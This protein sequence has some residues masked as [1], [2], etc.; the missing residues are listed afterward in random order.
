MVTGSGIYA[1][2]WGMEVL[3]EHSE[4]WVIKK[5]GESAAACAQTQQK[6]H[7]REW[8]GDWVMPRSPCRSQGAVTQLHFWGDRKERWLQIRSSVSMSQTC[9]WGWSQNVFNTLLAR[10]W[11]DLSLLG[12]ANM[13]L[14]SCSALRMILSS[15][16]RDPPQVRALCHSVSISSPQSLLGTEWMGG[17]EEGRR[18]EKVCS[19]RRQE[20]LQTTLSLN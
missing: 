17:K 6:V 18:E 2:E 15:N 7:N 10:L 9:P 3:T 19:A 5:I 13:A 16:P 11:R 4:D 20:I 12:L 1:D 8:E 14:L